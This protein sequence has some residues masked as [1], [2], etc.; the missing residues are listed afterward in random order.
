MIA[1]AKAIGYGRAR[2]DRCEQL[3]VQRKARRLR[4]SEGRSKND[5]LDLKAQRQQVT[6]LFSRHE[7]LS[8]HRI[9]SGARQRD[10]PAWFGQEERWCRPAHHENGAAHFRAQFAAPAYLGAGAEEVCACSRHRPRS[11]DNQQTRR[12]QSAKESRRHLK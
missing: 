6:R 11:Q 2:F 10:S 12:L 9:Q 7:S 5:P 4:Q 3:R 8:R 1:V